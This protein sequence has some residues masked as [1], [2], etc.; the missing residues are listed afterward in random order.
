MVDGRIVFLRDVAAAA[1]GLYRIH[2]AQHAL[3]DP[4]PPG[5]AGIVADGLRVSS[6]A[7]RP[8]GRRVLPGPYIDRAA[9]GRAGLDILGRPPI[10]GAGLSSVSARDHDAAAG[11]RL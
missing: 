3:C 9:S 6:A 7:W 11:N 5:L 2:E 8:P 4:R 10:E 1:R